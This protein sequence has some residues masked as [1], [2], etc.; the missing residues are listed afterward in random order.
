MKVNRKG[1]VGLVAAAVVAVGTGAAFA[2]TSQPAV[3]YADTS[4]QASSF[5][6]DHE[7]TGTAT[8]A[9]RQV[10]TG[11]DI[12]AVTL[13]G[14][15]GDEP[16]SADRAVTYAITSSPDIDGVTLSVTNSGAP[17]EVTGGIS[18]DGTLNAGANSFVDATAT[19]TATDTDG[20][21]AIVTVPVT[22]RTNSVSW[23][24]LA[25]LAITDEVYSI[26]AG[27]TNPNGSV[28]FA[29]KDTDVEAITIGESNLPAGLA[30]GNPL[31][32]GTAVP[33]KY[34][35][36]L[37]TATDASGATATGSFLLT[38]NGSTAPAAAVPVLSHGS[39]TSVNPVR[40][41]V[42]FDTTVSTWVH[43][44]ITGPGAINGHQGW[45]YAVAG[46]LNEAVYGGL[47][48]GHGYTVYYTPVEGKGSTVQV[49]GT[50]TGYVYFVTA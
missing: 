2:A 7:I 11:P 9:T 17:G 37:V 27:D 16:F 23:N 40:E 48:A 32:P 10:G 36:L 26:T 33:G 31:L 20:D 44:Q 3:T 4:V 19:L 12:Y 41:D 25:G 5:V 18:A 45:V 6:W 39:A 28:T 21:V 22:V 15:S 8:A 46:Q 35:D 34:K 43:F 1:V 29:A 24:H 13:T 50:T 49:P 14:L 47:E 30:S 42:Y 38:V